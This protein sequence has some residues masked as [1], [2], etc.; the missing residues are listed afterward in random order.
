MVGCC[1]DDFDVGNDC[2]WWNGFY[3]CFWVEV[4]Y[5]SVCICYVVVGSGCW[6]VY[7]GNVCFEWREFGDVYYV[8]VVNCY[9]LV[10]VFVFDFFN[11]FF[12]FFYCC[13]FFD[14]EGVY[15]VCRFYCIF[16]IFISYFFC[17]WVVDNECFFSKVYFFGNVN[18]FFCEVFV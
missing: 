3:G 13:V 18:N 16:Y 14:G 1:F 8:F 5:W 15:F 17:F 9:Y 12:D 6:K 4:F 2:N 11:C 7:E 10:D